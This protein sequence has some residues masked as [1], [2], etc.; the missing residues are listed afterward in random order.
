[1]NVFSI[2]FYLIQKFSAVL[3]ASQI[4]MIIDCVTYESKFVF[5]LGEAFSCCL[6]LK[7]KFASLVF[8]G[9]I[10]ALCLMK[11]KDEYMQFSAFSK[12]YV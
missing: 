12:E 4:T 2:L 5:N 7:V 8:H 1:M 10:H 11:R 9:Q 6:E 3:Q